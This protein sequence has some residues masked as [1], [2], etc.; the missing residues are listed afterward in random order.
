[1]SVSRG[2]RRNFAG[3]AF[4][5]I[6]LVLVLTLMSTGAFAYIELS[7]VKITQIS[8]TDED[9]GIAHQ[10]SDEDNSLML[11]LRPLPM[12]TKKYATL[13]CLGLIQAGWQTMF[14]ILIPL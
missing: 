5:W 10:P 14:R 7:K 13:P 11:V 8:R 3:S 2:L 6:G 12:T 1:M 4:A 9:L